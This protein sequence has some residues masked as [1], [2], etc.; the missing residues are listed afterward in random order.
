MA[1]GEIVGREGGLR[2]QAAA[3]GASTELLA[4]ARQL[5]VGGRSAGEEAEALE[6]QL[7]LGSEGSR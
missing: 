1:I 7:E 2:Q 3:L 4:L 6:M 5:A